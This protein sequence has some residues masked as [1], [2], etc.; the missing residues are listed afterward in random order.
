MMRWLVRSPL[1]GFIA[2]MMTLAITAAALP[3]AAQDYP[4]QRRNL[5][6]L[7]FGHFDHSPPR[8]RLAPRAPFP[9]APTRPVR[10]RKKPP[11]NAPAKAIT[12]IATPPAA[13]PA[14]AKLDNARKILV[15]GDFFASAVGDGLAEAFRDSPGTLIDIRSNGSS[16]LVRDDYYDWQRQVSKF[17]DEVK[18][19]VVV[20]A[21]GANDRQQMGA[22]GRDQR[23]PGEAW[24]EEYQKRIEALAHKVTDRR[25]ALIWTGL[26]PVK[27]PGIS[28]DFSRFNT[29]YRKTTEKLGGE[30]VD[31]WDGFVDEDGGFVLTGSDINGQQARLRGPDGVSMTQ[32]GKRKMAFFLEKPIR[33]RLGDMA[34]PGL[35]RLDL[36][37]AMQL[38]DTP[39][40]LGDEALRTPPLKISD[41]TLDGAK[42]LLGG[43]Q[44][45]AKPAPPSPRDLLVKTGIP[46]Q[47]PAGRLDDYRRPATS[48]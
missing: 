43:A 19:A 5:L 31:V 10:S 7:L 35:M 45:P 42:I 14:P 13:P 6:D 15:V 44:P 34:S 36:Q 9:Q 23:F 32:A 38:P 46:P 4:P 18:P 24:E 39:L 11:E 20:V 2:L 27:S 8:Y 33:K 3:A 17:L 37:P 47:A 25:I 21:L 16:G 1:H 40:N 22:S 30:F 12:P 41:P 26:P 29:F 28:S 48:P